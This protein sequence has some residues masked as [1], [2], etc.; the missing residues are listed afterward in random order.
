MTTTN[1]RTSSSRA[2]PSTATAAK[3]RFHQSVV[4]QQQ[5]TLLGPLHQ[6]ALLSTIGAY[7]SIRDVAQAAATCTAM[8]LKLPLSSRHS[9][10]CAACTV[11]DK[12]SITQ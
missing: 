11:T 12:R 7:L 3:R 10:L 5:P 6:D 1:Y 8:H 2:A 9:Q 4:V